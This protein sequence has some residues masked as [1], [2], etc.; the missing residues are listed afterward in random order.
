MPVTIKNN[1][2]CLVVPPSIRRRAGLKAG[3]K[4]E[5]KVSGGIINILPWLPSSNDEYTPEQ[6]RLISAQLDEAQK[7]PYYGPFETADAAAS[8]L[9]AEIRKRKTRSKTTRS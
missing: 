1:A 3:A 2:T 9:R 5:F 6:R 8:F 7:G 4:V